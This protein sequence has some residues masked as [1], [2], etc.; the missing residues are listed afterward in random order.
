MIIP[1]FRRWWR[2]P[3]EAAIREKLQNKP[4]GPLSLLSSTGSRWRWWA[5][6]TWSLFTVY[7]LAE[8]HTTAVTVCLQYRAGL[9]KEWVVIYKNCGLKSYFLMYYMYVKCNSLIHLK[10]LKQGKLSKKNFHSI[11][12][13]RNLM[14]YYSVICCIFNTCLI[15]ICA[16]TLVGNI[17]Q[18]IFL[19]FNYASFEFI[20]VYWCCPVRFLIRPSG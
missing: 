17:S 20:N 19:I 6:S 12:C 16:L 14:S 9:P 1:I 13:V 18:S 4:T 15:W 7:S 10:K 5:L 8:W 11:S 2:D 3:M